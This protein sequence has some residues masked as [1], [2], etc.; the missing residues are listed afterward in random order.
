[1]EKK[2]LRLGGA[3]AWVVL[4]ATGGCT[5]QP[6]PDA[7]STVRGAVTSLPSVT[8]Q[9]NDLGRTGANLSEVILT[10]SVVGTKGKFGKVG[11]LLVDGQ[12]YGQPL[13]VPGLTGFPGFTGTRNAVFV[14]TENNS[15]Y[16]FDADNLQM[17]L[18]HRTLE[19][20]WMP[21]SFC[22]N[23]AQPWGINSTPVIDP[24]TSTMYVA[25]RTAT[26]TNGARHLLHAVSL[27]DGTEKQ[28]G[29]LD[30]GVV[31][32]TGAAVTAPTPTGGTVTFDPNKHQN[33]VA[34]TLS[35]TN[36]VLS[37]GFG[38]YCDQD[39]FHGWLMRFDVS[40]TPITAWSPSS[41]RPT[42]AAA[43]SGRG[44]TASPTTAPARST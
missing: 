36:H 13:Y 2:V 17:S 21:A 43:P 9:H 35:P 33:R 5:A 44:A 15:V 41:P 24:A 11:R 7:T 1:M 19:A 6:E 8:T 18:W 14:A 20:A 25:V 16:A 31:T 27:I 42:P 39:S 12:I 3:L 32:S 4:V 10:P 23:S 26:A 34:L 30:M 40:T 29:P 28:S 37:V 38:S 22:G